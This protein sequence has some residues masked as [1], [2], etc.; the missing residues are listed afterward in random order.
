M[1][2]PDRV[3]PWIGLLLFVAACAAVPSGIVHLIV[4][5]GG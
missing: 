1:I 4:L 2:V 5:Y 3:W